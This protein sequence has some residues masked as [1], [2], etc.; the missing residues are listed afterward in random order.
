MKKRLIAVAVS[1]LFAAIA[2]MGTGPST[3]SAGNDWERAPHSRVG[4][5]WELAG[6]HTFGND[7][8]FGHRTG[9]DWE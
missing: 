6:P 7:W 8:E 1:C 2:F 9:N 4:N 3:S 5:D